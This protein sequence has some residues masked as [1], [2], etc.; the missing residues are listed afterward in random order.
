MQ[1]S[2]PSDQFW[3]QESPNVKNKA[4]SNEQFA[5]SLATGDYNDDGYLDLSIGV[6]FEGIGVTLNSG[7]VNVLYGSGSGLQTTSPA[8]QFWH[9]DVPDVEGNAAA[10]GLF[11]FALA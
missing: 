4:E 2:S 11:G 10:G 1:A 3:S 9:E 7:A 8:T 5:F 6:P